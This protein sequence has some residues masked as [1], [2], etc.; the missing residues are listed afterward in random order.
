MPCVSS[1]TVLGFI[2]FWTESNAWLSTSASDGGDGVGT[3]NPKSEPVAL[4]AARLMKCSVWVAGFQ[5][6]IADSCN[7]L[8]ESRNLGAGAQARARFAGMVNAINDT[9]IN[10]RVTELIMRST[11]R[12][13]SG[14]NIFS[15][16]LRRKTRG[17][18]N[19]LGISVL[20]LIPQ[21]SFVNHRSWTTLENE[22][23]L[24]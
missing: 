2:R 17:W 1:T 3:R 10:A 7:I 9:M 14:L 19:R 6:I 8:T 22:F 20:T 12:V 18:G 21:G 4:K 5:M 16:R 23:R 15:G 24:N 11:I 13:S